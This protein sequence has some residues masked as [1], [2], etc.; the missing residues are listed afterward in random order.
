MAHQPSDIVFSTCMRGRKG[1]PDCRQDGNTIAV[2][3][4]YVD[5][6]SQD[7]NH[8]LHKIMTQLED[9]SHLSYAKSGGNIVKVNEN[10]NLSGGRTEVQHD[11]KHIA[12][13]GFVVRQDVRKRQL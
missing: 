12:I 8:V 7:W 3:D 4:E 1:Y 6:A 2:E 11:F 9:G 10:R 5:G 13:R